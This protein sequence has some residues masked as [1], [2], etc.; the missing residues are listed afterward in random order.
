MTISLSGLFSKLLNS[1]LSQVVEEHNLLGECQ[2]G[3]RK[4]RCMADNS[5]ILDSILWK[6]K[7]DKRKVHLCYIDISKAYD[8][9]NR[10]ILWSKLSKLGFSGEFLGCLKALYCND[11]VDSVVNGISTQSVFLRRG[12]K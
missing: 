12:L 10:G 4:G 11:S 8:S 1:R 7:A 5:F 3:F 9:V 6:A 2:N